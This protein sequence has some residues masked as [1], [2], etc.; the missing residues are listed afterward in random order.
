MSEDTALAR[1][2]HGLVHDLLGYLDEWPD[3]EAD[4]VAVARFRNEG[5]D[6]DPE[7]LPAAV[8]LLV[9]LMWWLDTCDDDEVES[10]I[11]VKV[12]ESA[13]SGV[14]D[15][16]QARRQR[17]LAVLADLAAAEP[18]DGRAYELRFFPFAMGLVEDEPEEDAPAPR[19][20]VR[21]ADRQHA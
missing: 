10:H 9:D 3:D 2:L 8:G 11:A 21:P 17:L 4:P 15:L 5:G 6:T 13:V 14:D 18:H 20:Y 7:S 12:G 1:T 19:E 16:P